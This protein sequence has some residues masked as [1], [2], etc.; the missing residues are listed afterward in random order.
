MKS[1]RALMVATGLLSILIGSTYTLRLYGPTEAEVYEWG[2][3][4]V[5]A[6]VLS[7]G[8][9]VVLPWVA[10]I[11]AILTA[12]YLILGLMQVPPVILWFV[13]HGTG[14]SDY[15]PQSGF[16]AHWAYAIPHM[17]LAVCSFGTASALWRPGFRR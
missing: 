10:G 8:A 6:G 14:I 13:F 3:V 11:K 12:G 16:V 9:A 4:A 15:T 7:I 5:T 2:R 1:S 17:V